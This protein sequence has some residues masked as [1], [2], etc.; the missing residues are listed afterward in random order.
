MAANSSLLFFFFFC[1]CMETQKKLVCQRS[2]LTCDSSTSVTVTVNSQLNH[3]QT[4]LSLKGVVKTE[5]DQTDPKRPNRSVFQS[6]A[7]YSFAAVTDS[8]AAISNVSDQQILKC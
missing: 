3:G 1:A 7:T 2:L 8:F 6:P 4:V 5:E